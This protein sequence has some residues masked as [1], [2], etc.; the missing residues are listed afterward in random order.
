MDR[1][2]FTSS[3]D[4]AN[5]SQEEVVSSHFDKLMTL[6]DMLNPICAHIVAHNN[7]ELQFH[8]MPVFSEDADNIIG[9]LKNQRITNYG[10]VYNIN[11]TVES[12]GIFVE[13]IEI[14]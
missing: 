14:I 7:N 10:K 5:S 4:Y 3:I 1:L 9:Q 13:L 11:T 2:E 8:I 6:Y 12:N